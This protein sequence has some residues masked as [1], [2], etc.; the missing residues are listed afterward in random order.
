MNRLAAIRLT[1]LAWLGLAALT[2]VAAILAWTGIGFA[3]QARAQHA[4]TAA[5]ARAGAS[6][7]HPLLPPGQG[8]RGERAAAGEAL[9]AAIR[10]AARERHLLLEQAA[11][12]PPD[13]H[14]PDELAIAMS[15]SGPELDVLHFAHRLEAGRP[16]IRFRPWRLAR[17]GH[18]ETAVRLDARALAYRDYR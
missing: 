14:K 4:L 13:R 6:P 2:I 8:Y 16:V 7:I 18:G 12:L 15:V 3:K 17:T 5:L 9:L 10:A 1:P 11:L